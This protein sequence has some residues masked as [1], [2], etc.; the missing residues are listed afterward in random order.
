[1]AR[2][3]FGVTRRRTQQP[4]V[5]PSNLPHDPAKQVALADLAHAADTLRRMLDGGELLASHE[6]PPLRQALYV[7]DEAVVASQRRNNARAVVL[8]TSEEDVDR[9]ATALHTRY[10]SDVDTEHARDVLL[11]LTGVG[12]DD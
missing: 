4:T 11:R 10:R 12:G 9:L 7:L 5:S 1:M 3:S 6:A 2:D 8:T